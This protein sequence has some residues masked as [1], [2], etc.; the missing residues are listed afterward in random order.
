MG[1]NENESLKKNINNLKINIINNIKNAY[2]CCINNKLIFNNYN[3]I[4]ENDIFIWKHKIIE[5]INQQFDKLM[6]NINQFNF[7]EQ[8]NLNKKNYKIDKIQIITLLPCKKSIK[9]ENKKNLDFFNTKDIQDENKELTRIIQ[10]EAYNY[11]NYEEEKENENIA[12]FLKEVAEIS[13]KSYLQANKLFKTLFEEF[14]KSKKKNTITSLDNEQ[15]IKEF[16]NWVKQKEKK[17]KLKENEN[18]LNKSEKNKENENQK[19]FS[20]ILFNLTK[21]YL[22]CKLSFPIIEISFEKEEIYNSHKMI[23]FINRGPNRKVNFVIL[24]SLFSNGSFLENGK[25]WVFTY[26]ANTFKFIDSELECLAKYKN[27]EENEIFINNLKLTISLENKNHDIYCIAK[28]N[29]EIPKEIKYSYIFHFKDKNK[30]SIKINSK[31]NSVNIPKDCT[32][33]ECILEIG[34]KCIT[35]KKIQ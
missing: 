25:S 28:T 14:K 22:H 1:T 15:N 29:N 21:L 19:F 26:H 24:P 9:I 6:K 16:S 34:D 27:I 8:P 4:Y 17:E 33:Y 31:E 12:L 3:Y 30:K 10:K 13:R 11:I 35:S 20:N 2:P 5:I 7:K 18:S 23:D 32:F